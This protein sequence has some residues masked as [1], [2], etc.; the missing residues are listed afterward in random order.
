MNRTH[1]FAVAISVAAAGTGCRSAGTSYYTLLAPPPSAGA[2]TPT[3]TF[4]LDVLPVDVPARGRPR[5]DGGAREH[6]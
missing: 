4:Q 6:W 1:L 5:A 2:E 3:A